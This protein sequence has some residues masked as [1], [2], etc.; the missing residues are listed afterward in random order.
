MGVGLGTAAMLFILLDPM[1]DARAISQ[2]FFAFLSSYSLMAVPLFIFAS[3]LM[4]RTGMVTQLFRL[5]EALLSWIVG[6]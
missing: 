2:S 6:G 5:A 1:L 3:F 4:E